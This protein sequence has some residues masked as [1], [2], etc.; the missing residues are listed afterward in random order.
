MMK[1]FTFV[2]CAV[3]ALGLMVASPAEAGGGSTVSSG[4]AVGV[5]KPSTVK[6]KNNSGSAWYVGILPN[7]LAGNPKFDPARVAGA[8]NL[9]GKLLN[10]GVTL[11]Y[12]VPSGAGTIAIYVPALVP[13]SGP[14]PPPAATGSYSV[15]SGK[16]ANRKIAAGPVITP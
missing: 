6:I 8:K 9:G 11:V 16:T 10:P 15:P 4:G 1:R 12:P 3:V 14:M 13:A 7:S 5:K 2:A